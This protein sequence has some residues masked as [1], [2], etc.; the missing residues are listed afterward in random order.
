MSH[1]KH[2]WKKQQN[3]QQK[4]TSIPPMIMFASRYQLDMI[5]TATQI[6]YKELL[7]NKNYFV[8]SLILSV[9]SLPS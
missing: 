4:S 2:G 7:E 8:G 9:V 6:E 5:Q 3:S 1:N